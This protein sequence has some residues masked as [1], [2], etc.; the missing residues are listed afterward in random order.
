MK[1]LILLASSLLYVNCTAQYWSQDPNLAGTARWGAVG[2]AT[3]THG[4]IC[5]GVSNGGSNLGDLWQWNPTSNSWAQKADFPGGPR[6]EG[7]AFSINGIGYVGFGRLGPSGPFFNDLWAYDPA[8]NAWAQKA[9]L[10]AADRAAPGVFVLNGKAY[11]VSGCTGPAPYPNDLWEYDPATN[12]WTQRANLPFTGRSGPIAFAV[13]G[14]GYIG[15]GNDNSSDL[16]STDFW[17]YNPATDN[18]T[19]R[20]DVPGPARRTGNAFVVNNIPYAGGG[21]NG[22]SYLVD[23]YAYNPWANSWT[24][25]NNFGGAG[26]HTPVAFSI[27]GTGYMGTGSTSSGATAQFWEYK[28]GPVGID[29]TLAASTIHPAFQQDQITLNGWAPG[30]ADA[31][32]ILDASGRI[33][34]T[35]HLGSLLIEVPKNCSDGVYALL[36]SKGNAPLGTWRFAVLH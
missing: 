11:L 25:I 7:A 26:A 23:M 6:R 35:G 4:Y 1:P 36:L 17:A 14:K 22:S 18:W 20:A 9:S 30:L 5:T 16:N 3:A 12:A 32:S 10:P 19:Q 31:Y 2:F 13:W 27:G 24:T 8:T 33:I 21:W 29:E 34:S 15:G 28:G